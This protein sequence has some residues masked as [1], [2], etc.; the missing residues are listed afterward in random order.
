MRRP[1]ARAGRGVA[2]ALGVAALAAGLAWAPWSAVAVAAGAAALAAAVRWPALA[3]AAAVAWV[4]FGPQAALP[5]GP[6]QATP[7]SPLVALAGVGVML[8]HLGLRRRPSFAPAVPWLLGLAALWLAALVASA[9]DAP[10]ATTAVLEVVRWGVFAAALAVAGTLTGPTGR[11]LAFVVLAAL[12]CAGAAEA[13]VG[14]RMALDGVGPRPFQLPGGRARA[15]GNFGQPNPFGGYMNLVWPLAAAV[16]VERA[17]PRRRRPDGRRV[18]PAG[19]T[20]PLVAL[21]GVAAA[22]ALAGLVLSW[23]RGAWLA[24]AAAAAAMTALRLA[25]GLRPP[26]D[27]LALLLPYAAVTAA[28]AAMAF[29]VAPGVPAAVAARAATITGAA[30]AGAA[31]RD[32]AHADITGANFSTIER[33]AHWDAALRMAA[34][35]PWLG[36]GP[37]HYALRYADYRLPR[38]PYDLGHAHNAYLNAWAEVGLLGLAAQ[39]ALFAAALALAARA[40][41][42]PRGALEGALGLGLAG[43]LAATAVH[44]LFDLLWVHDMTVTVAVLVGLTL[45]ARTWPAAPEAPA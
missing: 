40:A 44:S 6:A 38:W 20:W 37:G 19:A 22:A 34:D 10:S 5:L 12:L 23:S 18:R 25:A 33:L 27:G 32:L 15:F 16:V 35:R 2:A 26:R 39:G 13:V 28:L 41:V 30:G 1:G 11:R 31:G 7:P 36:Q 24:A 9:L 21:A 42:A 17:W 43:S 29:G 14:S 4:P 8:G 3:L 45:A